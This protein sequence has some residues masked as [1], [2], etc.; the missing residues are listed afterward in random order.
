MAYRIKGF[1][2]IEL[3]IVIAIISILM[4][5]A[6]PA[7]RDYTIRTKAGEGIS[8]SSSLKSTISEIWLS[9]NSL[10][11]VNSGTNGIGAATSYVGN[12]VS[13]IQVDQGVIEVSYK[14]DPALAGQTLTMTPIQPGSVDNT[15]SSLIWQCSSS[16][17][18]KY[19]PVSCRTP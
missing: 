9:T 19:L 14:D 7:Y 1:T 2:L 12:N 5:Y 8:M 4:V 18:N 3:M 15:G 10:A 13:Q 6:I 16:L 11:G 17:N